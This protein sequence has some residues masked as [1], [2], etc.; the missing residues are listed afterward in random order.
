MTAELERQEKLAQSLNSQF[1]PYNTLLRDQEQYRILYDS[2][3][4]RMGESKIALR[5]R[6]VTYRSNRGN[7]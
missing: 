7:A 4:K 5:F 3:I 1:I 2:V 6:S